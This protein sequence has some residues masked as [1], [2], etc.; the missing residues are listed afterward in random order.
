MFQQ[1]FKK[2]RQKNDY[3]PEYFSSDLKWYER[4]GLLTYIDQLKCNR[5]LEDPDKHFRK[6][7]VINFDIIYKIIT[8]ENLLMKLLRIIKPLRLKGQKHIQ[9]RSI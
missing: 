4:D 5:F 1:E 3:I 9:K 2:I 6:T 7:K 8:G